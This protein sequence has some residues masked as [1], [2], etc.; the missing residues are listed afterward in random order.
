[1]AAV[2]PFNFGESTPEIPRFLPDKNQWPLALADP[3]LDDWDSTRCL[4]RA[5]VDQFLQW[6][7]C[8]SVAPRRFVYSYELG[9]N[10]EDLPAWARYRKAFGFYN[11]LDH[12]ADAHGFGPFPGPGEC[13][14]IGPA[15][16]RSLYPTLERWFGIP[17]PFSD[18]SVSARPNLS[19]EP[20]DR[21][22]EDELAALTPALAN[23]L[24]MKTV[25]ELARELGQAKVEAARAQLAKLDPKA[26]MEWLQTKWRKRLGEIDAGHRPEA[27]V[28]WT[29]T[30]P[31][32]QAE[33]IT[34]AI[35]PDILVP[36]LLLRPTGN[37][38]ARPSVVV[39]VSE[40]GKELFLA[41]RQDEIAAMLKR[42]IAVCLPDVRGTG[43]TSA[44]SR[45]DPDSD[46]IMQATNE[47]MLGNS[48]L[49]DRLKDLRGVLAYLAGRPDLDSQRI[50]LWGDSFSPANPPRLA[51]D[52]MPQ[53]QVGPDIEHQAEPLGGLLAILSAVYEEHVRAVAAR[54]TLAGYSSILDDGFAYVPADVIAPR[55]LDAGDVADLAAAI[56]PRPLLLEGM[57]DA[58]GRLLPESALESQLQPLYDA[59]RG[60]ASPSLVVRA[61]PQT[62][63][64]AEWF[65]SHLGNP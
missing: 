49:G 28:R 11:A 52:E 35:E 37:A 17:I 27:T 20:L 33:A 4:W 65:V 59:Y 44:D 38:A 61:R 32:A 8:V 22:P 30:V 62:A 40:A 25:H 7:I 64:L 57:V 19:R 5:V 50:G 21:R 46:E 63:D 56:S 15:Q 41:A 31:N 54:G 60:P 55:L 34:L 24:H 10:V 36:L 16:R 48:L 1:V 47:L 14:N 29:K 12:L 42:G 43:E 3:G 58:R 2:V 13:W 6:T 51:L 45:R 23:E 39:A 9:W 53:W 26:R 18:A